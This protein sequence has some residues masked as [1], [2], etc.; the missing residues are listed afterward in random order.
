MLSRRGARA[1]LAIVPRARSILDQGSMGSFC[2]N[3]KRKA[4]CNHPLLW[5]LGSVG[6][7]NAKPCKQAS[8]VDQGG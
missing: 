3:H 7:L 6:K 4:L 5:V 2:L 8:E 1:F